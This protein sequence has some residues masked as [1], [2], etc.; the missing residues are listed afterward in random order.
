MPLKLRLKSKIEVKIS[1][2][3]QIRS[4]SEQ[5]SDTKIGCISLDVGRSALRNLYEL[6][7]GPKIVNC[8]CMTQLRV[9]FVLYQAI[10]VKI[11]SFLLFFWE[12]SFI[13]VVEMRDKGEKYNTGSFLLHAKV[14][15]FFFFEPQYLFRKLQFHCGL[16]VVSFFLFRFQIL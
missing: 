6:R 10:S 4:L 7:M 12:H 1:F 14:V 8:R 9:S 15:G 13:L 5:L 2:Q 3:P 11:C 16:V